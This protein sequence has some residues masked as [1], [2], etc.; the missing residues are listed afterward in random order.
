[1]SKIQTRINIEKSHLNWLMEMEKLGVNK[2]DVV[3]IA[4]TILRPRLN[5]LRTTNERIVEVLLT[6]QPEENL[7]Y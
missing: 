7:P 3:N 1:M 5:N 4:L 2:S 6:K